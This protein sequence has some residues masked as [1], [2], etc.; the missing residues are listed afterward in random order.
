ME[1]IPAARLDRKKMSMTSSI[2]VVYATQHGSTQEVAEAIAETLRTHELQVEIHPA[3]EVQTLEGYSAV[4][5]GAP[6]YTGHWNKDALKF[7]A[8]HHKALTGKP[9]AIFAL[10]PLSTTEDDWRSAR[11]QLDHALAKAPWLQPVAIEMFGGVIDPAKLHFP[12]NRMPAGDARNWTEI[13]VFADKLATTLQP[14][15]VAVN[16]L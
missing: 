14:T 8:R 12:F 4:V 9:V 10:G 5:L 3:R 6:I 15:K 2:L 16:P 11:Q 13:R 7:L 1:I